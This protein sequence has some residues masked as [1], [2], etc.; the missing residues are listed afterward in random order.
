LLRDANYAIDEGCTT[1][2]PQFK[3]LLLRA[4][5]IVRRRDDLK[6]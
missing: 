6:D 5:A 2:A 1:F 3:W 4:I